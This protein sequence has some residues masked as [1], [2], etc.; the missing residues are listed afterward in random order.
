MREE[1]L[2]VLQL[3]GQIVGDED[4]LFTLLSTRRVRF[5]AKSDWVKEV[6]IALVEKADAFESA[7]R[8]SWILLKVCPFVFGVERFFFSDGAVGTASS[9]GRLFRVL[10]QDVAHCCERR[11]QSKCV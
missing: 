10:L 9:F 3:V 11:E 8:E 6:S 7:V 2:R 5:D 4:A 1:A